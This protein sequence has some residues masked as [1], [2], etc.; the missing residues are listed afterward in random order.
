MIG[1]SATP[2]TK[3]L[4]QIYT[5]LVNVTT[6]NKLIADNWLVPLQVYAARAVD[7]TGAKVVAG[8]WS[9]KEIEQRGMAI[10]G[11]IVSEWIDKTRL[12]FG[13]PVKTIVFSATVEHGAEL[14]RQFNEQ[15]ST[16]SRSAIA[17]GATSGGASSSKNS[18]SL[19]RRSTASFRAKCSRRDFDVSDILCGIAARPYRKSRL[20]IF[21]SS[22]A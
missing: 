2:F 21:S 3:G 4:S 22:G 15:D 5:N 13:G 20:A 7:M 6:T 19:I 8:E 1:L 17:T 16:S 9:D 12:H 18:A 14:C 11:D 10:I